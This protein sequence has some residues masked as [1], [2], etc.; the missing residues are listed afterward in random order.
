MAADRRASRVPSAPT[1]PLMRRG[2][3]EVGIFRVGEY[4]T[5]AAFAPIRRGDNAQQPG[6][7]RAESWATGG[8]AGALRAEPHDLP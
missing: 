8:G 4:A 6:R 2:H 5:I 3:S 7:R 1:G